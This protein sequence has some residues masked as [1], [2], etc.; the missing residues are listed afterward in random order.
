MGDHQAT[1]GDL[2]LILRVHKGEKMG[3]MGGV[4]K[5]F[6]GFLYSPWPICDKEANIVIMGTIPLT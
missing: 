2:T 5:V 3:V 1:F 6:K 4:F